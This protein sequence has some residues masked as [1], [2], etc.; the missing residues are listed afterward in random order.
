MKHGRE[1]RG[2]AGGGAVVSGS[3]VASGGAVAGSDMTVSA[4]QGMAAN[5]GMAA[6]AGVVAGT[7]AGAGA[8]SVRTRKH[9]DAVQAD[10]FWQ[11]GDPVEQTLGVDLIGTDLGPWHRFRERMAGRFSPRR[12]LRSCASFLRRCWKRILAICGVLAVVAALIYGGLM[13]ASGLSGDASGLPLPG[14]AA[15]P[16]SARNGNALAVPNVNAPS[17]DGAAGSSGSAAVPDLSAGQSGAAQSGAQGAGTQGTGTQGI[18]VPKGVIIANLVDDGW[19]QDIAQ[20]SGIPVDYVKAYAG[21]SIQAQ[22]QYPHCGIG[23]NML[24][25]I[26]EV[27]SDHGTK[28]AP[29]QLIRGPVLDGSNGTEAMPD[30]DGGKLDGDPNWD[31][32]MGPMQFVPSTWMRYGLDGDGDARADPDDIN[33]AALTAAGY[34]CTAGGDLTTSQGWITAVEAYNRGSQ[35]NA[36]VANAANRLGAL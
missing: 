29:G 1:V 22:R 5:G 14:F 7:G 21:A 28:H 34:L 13:I 12:A 6:N 24:G 16:P 4:G 2:T 18:S 35:Y 23:W 3:A 9:R 19:A 10:S 25:G 26:G 30:T 33:D 20:R 17:R 8:E 11:L 32:A 27:E 15:V 36:A 31:R